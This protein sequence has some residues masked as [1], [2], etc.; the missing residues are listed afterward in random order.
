MKTCSSCKQEKPLNCFHN[1]R[2]RKD[3]KHPYCKDCR[4]DKATSDE[5]LKE[6]RKEWYFQNKEDV[7]LR[8]TLRYKNCKEE[9]QEYRRK[10]YVENEDRYK[11]KAMKYYESNKHDPEY[12]E[13][14]RQSVRNW[15]SRNKHIVAW[16]S[17]LRSC[18]VRLGQKK[19]GSTRELLGYSPDDLRDHLENL[20]LPDMSWDNYGEWHIDHIKPV[21]EFDRNTSP[22]VVNALSNLRPLWASTKIV[23]G[24]EIV[25]NLN[26]KKGRRK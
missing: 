20:W 17:V 9:I 18:V 5:W 14:R 21:V 19:T 23:E 16:R 6:Y 13:K 12:L 10:H 24:I 26:R 7:I 22:S 2:K 8:Q 11:E 1:N 4:K 3:G 25:G 15:R